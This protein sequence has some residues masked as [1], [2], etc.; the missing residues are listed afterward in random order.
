MRSIYRNDGAELV[1]IMLRARKEGL[2]TSVDFSLPDPTSP[3]GQADWPE[4]LTN[5]LPFVDLF[6]PSIEELLF[7]LDRQR[8]ENLNKKNS[9]NWLLTVTPKDLH[10]LGDRVLSLGVKIILI[11]MGHQGIYLRTAKP[12]AWKKAGRALAGLSAA[13][14][15]RELWIPA[16][17]VNVKG[18]CGAGDA[19]IAGFLSS[20]LRDND[21]ETSLQTAAAAGA[22]SVEHL[23]AISG[24]DSWEALQT[25]I[26][27][28]WPTLPIDLSK[29][30][31][32][33]D[34]THDI[35]QSPKHR[36]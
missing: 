1:S 30:G 8:F 25:D 12:F 34:Q 31:W 24:L 9:T 14:A 18:T 13:W 23:D 4:I 26:K 36:N 11:K 3:A 20:L 33:K 28:G 10:Q 7:M 2:T 27:N 5:A 19:A 15:D 32:I 35:W 17:A 29:S 22:K 21:P 16:Y 6:M